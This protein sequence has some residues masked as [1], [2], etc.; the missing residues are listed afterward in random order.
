MI[1]VYIPVFVT[2]EPHKSIK[3]GTFLLRTLVQYEHSFNKL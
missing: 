3:S 2:G 1:I